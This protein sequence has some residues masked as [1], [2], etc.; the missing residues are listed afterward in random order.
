MGVVVVQSKPV[1]QVYRLFGALVALL[2]VMAIGFSVARW[3]AAQSDGSPYG[4]LAPVASTVVPV[5][6][7][8]ARVAALSATPP[9]APS[10]PSPTDLAA[11]TPAAAAA[12]AVTQ[13]PAAVAMSP[14][15]ATA[16]APAI[17]A[18]A[19]SA[20]APAPVETARAQP[21]VIALEKSPAGSAPLPAPAA[22]V[23]A[24]T[25]AQLAPPKPSAV[26]P[27][28]AATP[29][30]VASAAPATEAA[31]PGGMININTASADMLDHLPGAGRIGKTIVRH[32]PYG[33]V[34]DLVSHR[35]LKASDF[36][37]I[38]SHL[39]AN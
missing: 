6:A 11:T 38:R 31:S 3:R 28:P 29:T 27:T 30:A 16:S 39:T 34:E 7:A 5:I 36:A 18:T 17:G 10:A 26:T 19:N 22:A 4:G 35:V 13:Q 2:L 24:A 20:M 12:P 8:P 32:R 23:A 14:A 25:A 37:R 33:S 21:R 15:L 1:A 9:I